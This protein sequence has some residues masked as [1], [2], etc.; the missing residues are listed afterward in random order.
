VEVSGR[1]SNPSPPG[2]MSVRRGFLRP[3]LTD[4]A[5]LEAIGGLFRRVGGETKRRVQ[6][7]SL[8]PARKQVRRRLRPDEIEELIGEYRAGATILELSAKHKVHRTTLI[9]LL[10]RNAVARRG[11]VITPDNI[12]RAIALYESGESCAAISRVLRT[13]PE[14]IRQSL[15][16]AGVTLR[17][18]GRPKS[19]RMPG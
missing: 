7:S 13:S 15:L 17:R 11:R 12:N 8:P 6:E 2:R 18:P 1:Y 5:L 19:R 10:E 9:N 16:K 3:H 14:T 4:P